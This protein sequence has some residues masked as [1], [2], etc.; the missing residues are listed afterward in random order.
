MC[1]KQ[2]P[3][4]EGYSRNRTLFN[5]G[6]QPGTKAIW[7]SMKIDKDEYKLHAGTINIVAPGDEFAIYPNRTLC[8]FP[9]V[10]LFKLQAQGSC[11]IP[12][13]ETVFPT[14]L[15]STNITLSPGSYPVAV[16]TRNGQEVELPSTCEQVSVDPF[17]ESPEPSPNSKRI[18]RALDAT[19]IP[20]DAGSNPAAAIRL[21][22]T[23]SKDK[24]CRLIVPDFNL[25][26]ELLERVQN[27]L[28]DGPPGTLD[29]TTVTEPPRASPAHSQPNHTLSLP[30]IA[31]I[32]KNNP[33]AS[34][35]SYN[36]VN[37]SLAKVVKDHPITSSSPGRVKTTVEDALTKVGIESLAGMKR[38]RMQA[39]SS[40]TRMHGWKRL[41]WALAN[42]V[43]V[44][45]DPRE[46]GARRKV[47]AENGAVMEREEETV[48]MRWLNGKGQGHQVAKKHSSLVITVN[49]TK[50]AD[51][52]ER[53]ITIIRAIC[54]I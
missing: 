3:Q 8:R 19:P 41:R 22:I 1:I 5:L 6:V 29:T 27:A 53:K 34:N 46:E 35:S 50:L 36:K 26:L 15:N 21:I 45:F 23:K 30:D 12:Q 24:G 44:E 31:A 7:Y 13:F 28:V 9:G 32:F 17:V 33:I 14:S 43:P 40:A 47:V 11:T 54:N 37:I 16:R 38:M 20:P 2:N 51:L 48:G 42:F 52:M 39:R 18:S 10:M 4:W 49:S 25:A